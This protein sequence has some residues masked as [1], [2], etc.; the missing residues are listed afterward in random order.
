MAACLA[1][2][3]WAAGCVS[4]VAP[5]VVLSF[6]TVALAAGEY[7]ESIT[8]E[9]RGG[10]VISINRLVDDWDAALTWDSPELLKVELQARHFSSGLPN[11]ARLNRFLTLEAIGAAQPRIT[12]TIRI[13]STEPSGRPDRQLTLAEKDLLLTPVNRVGR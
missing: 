8:V 6:P 7:V 1:L 9:V 5:R 2:I 10:R 13:E 4:P 11:L 3:V 12:A